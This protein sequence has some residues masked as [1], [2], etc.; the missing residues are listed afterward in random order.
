MRT[1]PDPID[2][3]QLAGKRQPLG[4]CQA[5][6]W[7][8]FNRLYSPDDVLAQAHALCMLNEDASRACDTFVTRQ[9]P[10]F[11]GR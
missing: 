3:T 7:G 6:R 11:V 4:G 5:E 8:F 1:E 2:A 9:K 10:T